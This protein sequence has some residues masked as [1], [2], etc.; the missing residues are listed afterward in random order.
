MKI[1]SEL[2]HTKMR[3]KRAA[4]DIIHLRNIVAKMKNYGTDEFAMAIDL[5]RKL[6]ERAEALEHKVNHIE[7]SLSV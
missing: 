2:E 3:C 6:H 1:Y 7:K 5:M 4:L